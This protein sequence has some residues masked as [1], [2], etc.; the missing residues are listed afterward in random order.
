M[1]NTVKT[2]P[3]VVVGLTPVPLTTVTPNGAGNGFN[4]QH[5][6]LSVS[7]QYDPAGTGILYVGDNLVSS[8]RYSR[9]LAPGDFYTVAGSAVDPSRVFVVASVAAQ[10]AFPSWN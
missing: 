2:L 8:T 9:A 3:A 6:G 4:H 1:P 5:F 7:V 10:N